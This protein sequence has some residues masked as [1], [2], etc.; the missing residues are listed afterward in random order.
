MMIKRLIFIMKI[1]KK[2]NILIQENDFIIYNFYYSFIFD[3][4]FF[5]ILSK[6]NAI[7][8]IKFYDKFN[9]FSNF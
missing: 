4:I 3:F 7:L 2:I 8:I 6:F 9:F 5:I 1:K